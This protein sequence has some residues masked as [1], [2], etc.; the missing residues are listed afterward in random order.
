ML[1]PKNKLS[2]QQ[3]AMDPNA[4]IIP[5]PIEE[6]KVELPLGAVNSSDGQPVGSEVEDDA[7]HP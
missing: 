7:S 6:E 2:G 3:Q 1:E 4:T 5:T